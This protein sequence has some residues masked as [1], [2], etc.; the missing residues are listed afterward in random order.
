MLPPDLSK[1]PDIT[2]HAQVH[3]STV[4]LCLFI[5]VLK[6]PVFYSRGR[7]PTNSRDADY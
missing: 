2:Y 5:E 3:V 4:Y 6:R 7:V 1:M